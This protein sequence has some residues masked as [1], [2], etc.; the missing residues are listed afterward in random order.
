M[1]SITCRHLVKRFAS[2]SVQGPVQ[3]T[4]LPPI[5]DLSFE[6][7]AG[8]IT[9]IIGQ[10]GCGKTTLLRMIAG[11]ETPDAGEIVFADE[12][13]GDRPRERRPV[14][15]TVFQEPRLFPWLNV[16]DNI[17]LAVRSRPADEKK[18]LIDET[19]ETVGLA[20]AAFKMPHELSGGMAQRVGMARALCRH[21][22]ILLLDEAFS[23]LDALTREKLRGEFIDIASRRPMTTILVTH[24]VLE[25]VLLSST[26]CKLEA[27]VISRTWTIGAPYPRRLG[28][29]GLAEL[30]DGILAS[31]FD[32][33]QTTSLHN[34]SF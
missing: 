26:V 24:D 14:V 27:G 7:P 3:A 20:S 2:N 32:Q 10:S 8:K 23:A 34:R 28:Q 19:L 16:R 15:S 25:A 30:A 21:P 18:A 29:Q 33:H 5:E 11:L 22:D 17:G 1:F 9:A 12:G 31:F 4:S 13:A 6:F